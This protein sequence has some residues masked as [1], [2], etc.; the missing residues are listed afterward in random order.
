[1]NRNNEQIIEYYFC[2]TTIYSG[3]IT[4]NK[5]KCLDRKIPTFYWVDTNNLDNIKMF[6]KLNLQ[7]ININIINHTIEKTKNNDL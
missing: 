3:K 6:S 1:M 5:F 7:N 2:Y 4:E